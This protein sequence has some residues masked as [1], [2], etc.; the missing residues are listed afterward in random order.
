LTTPRKQENGE[1]Y[2]SVNE[3]C[4][5]RSEEYGHKKFVAGPQKY[6]VVEEAEGSQGT[7]KVR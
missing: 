1:S 5:T 3:S 7:V 6:K 2:T 4:G